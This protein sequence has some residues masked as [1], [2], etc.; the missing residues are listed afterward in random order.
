MILDETRR[1]NIKGGIAYGYQGHGATIYSPPDFL[2]GYEIGCHDRR[3][4]RVNSRIDDILGRVTKL[5]KQHNDP[6]RPTDSRAL[7]AEDV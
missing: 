5:E 3:F 2:I 1:D 7:R 4:E 6:T